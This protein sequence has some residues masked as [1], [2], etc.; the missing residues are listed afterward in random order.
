MLDR[1]VILFALIH[2]HITLEGDG[3]GGGVARLSNLGRRMGAAFLS[4]PA[5]RP[6]SRLNFPDGRRGIRS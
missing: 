6:H 2:G 3:G 4:G 1:H 5:W